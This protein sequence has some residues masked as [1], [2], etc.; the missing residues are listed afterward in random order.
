MSRP[1]TVTCAP[2][3]GVRPAFD[4]TV[5][6]PVFAD[7]RIVAYIGNIAHKPDLGGKVPGT[8]SPDATD[9]LQEGLLLPALRLYRD[10]QV[11][12]D[13]KEII[14]ANTREFDTLDKGTYTVENIVTTVSGK[15]NIKDDPQFVDPAKGDYK[16][17]PG[18]KAI[19]AGSSS[20]NLGAY[21]K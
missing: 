11:N 1:L 10:E 16:L 17:K 18:S 12:E 20:T 5:I 8:N 2:S 6:S 13:I 15:G 21:P 7:E 19:G 14:W 9:L 4:V 3:A